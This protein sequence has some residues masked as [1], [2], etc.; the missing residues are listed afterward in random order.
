MRVR[1]RLH[2]RPRTGD[3]VVAG[4]PLVRVHQIAGSTARTVPAERVNQGVIIGV[5]RAPGQDLG[6]G[7]RQLADIAERALS[8]AV[9][10]VTTAVRAV[11]EAHT[12]FSADSPPAPTRSTSS[13]TTRTG[14]A[15]GSAESR[16]RFSWP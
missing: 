14:S 16:T 4:A 3:F 8:P 10:D 11:Q 9:N 15:S 2:R 6:F 1:L 12:T 13:A 7:F 5:E